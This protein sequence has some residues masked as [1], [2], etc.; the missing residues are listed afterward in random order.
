MRN[1]AIYWSAR[2]KTCCVTLRTHHTNVR[3]YPNSASTFCPSIE[4]VPFFSRI[5][6]DSY[7]WLIILG[8]TGISLGRQIRD[9]CRRTFVVEVMLSAGLNLYG[10]DLER[11]YYYSRRDSVLRRLTVDRVLPIYGN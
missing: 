2:L 3:K 1:V 4:C 11:M 8:V 9:D 6:D 10:L 5:F 7:D